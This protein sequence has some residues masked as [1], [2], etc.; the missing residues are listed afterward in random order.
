MFYRSTQLLTLLNVILRVTT[1]V[2]TKT[3]QIR[4]GDY[5]L[6]SMHEV[7][8]GDPTL[9]RVQNSRFFASPDSLP[10]KVSPS[11]VDRN[12][13][14]YLLKTLMRHLQSSNSQLVSLAYESLNRSLLLL[15]G[16]ELESYVKIDLLFFC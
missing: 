6:K 14:S 12:F 11:I 5:H 8:A 3:S 1:R 15:R 7:R 13:I 10:T 16:F 2:Y 4:F 9:S